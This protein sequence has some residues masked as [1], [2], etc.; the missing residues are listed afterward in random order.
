MHISKGFFARD[1]V[2]F[3]REAIEII[4]GGKTYFGGKSI[5]LI[6]LHFIFLFVETV[7]LSEN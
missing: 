6:H 1:S 4:Y 5:D 3:L 7:T 2:Y